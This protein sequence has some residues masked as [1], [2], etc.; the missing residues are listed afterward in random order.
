[1][2]QTILTLIKTILPL[3]VGIYLFW[4][5]FSKMSDEHIA[6]FYKAI[7]EANYFWVVVAMFLEFVSLWSRAERWKYMLEP[8]GYSTPWKNRYHSMMIGYL[9][10][11]TLPRAGEPTRSAMLFRSNGVPFAKSF[12]TIIA[13]RAVDVLMLGAVFGFT[14]LISSS[15]LSNIFAQIETNFSGTDAA[16]DGISLKIIINSV[17]LLIAATIAILF[18]FHP[19]FKKKLIEFVNGVLNGAFSI[20]KTDRPFAFIAHTILIWLCWIL[21]FIIPFYSLKETSNVPFSGMM[22]GFIVGTLGMSFTNGGIGIY[23]LVVG[24]V[25]SLYLQQD[26]PQEAQGIGN[27]LGM[28]IWLGNTF[29]MILLGLISLILLP[30]KYGTKD[31]TSR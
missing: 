26:Y 24:Y 5:F 21:M 3:G 16:S 23:P 30:K 6:S 15:D 8:M 19:T 13:E 28:I 27:A 14:L 25:V 17:L 20:F 2:K 11:Y 1:M 31:D 9:A 18:F 12:G 4:L 29:I 22:I 7:R 10:N